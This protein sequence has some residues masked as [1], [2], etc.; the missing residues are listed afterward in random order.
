METE[1]TQDP[2][3]FGC[4]WS[5]QKMFPFRPLSTDGLS[6]SPPPEPSENCNM[7][8][9]GLAS[10]SAYTTIYTT[11]YSNLCK[12]GH[13]PDIAVVYK[14]ARVPTCESADPSLESVLIA[15]PSPTRSYPSLCMSHL[16]LVLLLLFTEICSADHCVSSEVVEVEDE[17]LDADLQKIEVRCTD[18]KKVISTYY[19]DKEGPSMQSGKRVDRPKKRSACVMRGHSPS[20][21]RRSHRD[22]LRPDVL[23]LVA[24]ELSWRGDVPHKRFLRRFIPYFTEWLPRLPLHSLYSSPSSS[25]L[26]YIVYC[27]NANISGTKGNHVEFELDPEVSA[28]LNDFFDGKAQSPKR[29]STE[30]PFNPNLAVP[31]K[32]SGFVKKSPRGSPDVL[33]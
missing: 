2:D 13:R 7:D 3:L 32:P 29:V 4:H 6:S 21:R 14:C 30:R 22:D 18:T 20:H 9:Q 23:L 19:M 11:Y 10:C 31:Q 27:A 16:C 28:K 5:P 17:N 25:L 8:P 24:K 33:Q 15:I 1:K 12:A 26:R